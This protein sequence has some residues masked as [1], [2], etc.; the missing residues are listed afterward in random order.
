MRRAPAGSPPARSLASRFGRSS[1]GRPPKGKSAQTLAL[2]PGAQR[3]PMP[4]PRPSAKR[5]SRSRMSRALQPCRLRGSCRSSWITPVTW[6]PMKACIWRVNR[7]SAGS[8]GPMARPATGAGTRPL[9]PHARPPLM[10]LPPPARSGAGIGPICQ[11]RLPG[12]GSTCISFSIST[13]ARSWAIRSPTP[14]ILTTRRISRDAPLLPK[15][16]TAFTRSR[17][18]R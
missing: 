3:R 7:P 13:A 16:F 18:P 5:C 4:C 9:G 11:P 14:M 10:W 17:A 12:A 1:A 8:C 2:T 6:G 15:E